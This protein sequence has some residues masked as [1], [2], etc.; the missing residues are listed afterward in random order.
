MFWVPGLPPYPRVGRDGTSLA[1]PVP[2]KGGG[3]AV[4]MRGLALL[5]IL[6]GILAWTA[7]RRSPWVPRRLM[8]LPKDVKRDLET[9]AIRWS[10]E[11]LHSMG[12]VETAP[13]AERDAMLAHR[14][15]SAVAERLQAAV[16]ELK[17]I[18]IGGIIHLEGAVTSPEARLEA[19]RVAQKVSG[20][21]VVADDLR[22]E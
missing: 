15:A 11:L 10:G 17:V 13:R 19:E 16:A 7:F 2:Q 21:R 6:G 14:V 5:S 1:G 18:I 22:V 20:A 8:D 3:E 12:A 9:G 4:A